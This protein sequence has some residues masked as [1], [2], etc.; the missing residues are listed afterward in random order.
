MVLVLSL[1]TWESNVIG[2]CPYVTSL[3]KALA[4]VSKTDFHL[5]KE[6]NPCFVIWMRFLSFP[7]VL[8][9]GVFFFSFFSLNGDNYSLHLSIL[10]AQL[11]QWFIPE[12]YLGDVPFWLVLFFQNTP[13]LYETFSVC[14][15]KNLCPNRT[16]FECFLLCSEGPRRGHRTAADSATEIALLQYIWL[17]TDLLQDNKA[18]S[19]ATAAPKTTPLQKRPTTYCLLLHTHSNYIFQVEQKLRQ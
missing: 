11:S 6:K 8:V 17:W 2:L 15:G 10:S 14:Q 13:I 19:T 3:Q 7:G 12:F 18:E 5:W 1:F 4:L 16:C 9:F